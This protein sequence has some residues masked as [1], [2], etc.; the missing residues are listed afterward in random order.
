MS[1][2]QK[3]GRIVGLLFH[4]TKEDGTWGR[5]LVEGHFKNTLHAE[6]VGEIVCKRGNAR[7][8]ELVYG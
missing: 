7:T 2:K 1:K 4:Y 6:G 3:K 5:R 8:Y